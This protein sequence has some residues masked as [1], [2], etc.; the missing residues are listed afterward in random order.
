[1]SPSVPLSGPPAVGVRGCVAR[2]PR[3]LEERAPSVS[4]KHPLLSVGSRPWPLRLLPRLPGSH[5]QLVSGPLS[6]ALAVAC[7]LSPLHA[8]Y[9]L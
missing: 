8:P 7:G 1:M 2:V 4:L 5:K 6:V 9:R 3:A